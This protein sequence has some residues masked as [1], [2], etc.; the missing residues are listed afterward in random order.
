MKE[1]LRDK[2]RVAGNHGPSTTCW[3]YFDRLHHAFVF[4]LHHV[5]VKNEPSH[6]F[7]I[8]ERNDQLR[9]PGLP[10]SI[11]GTLKVSRR[12]SKCVG[13]PF[14]SVTRNPV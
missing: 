4:V 7:G 14:T 1:V 10:L 2:K 9:D 11:G 8:G 3:M 13:T 6:D 5:T 12:P